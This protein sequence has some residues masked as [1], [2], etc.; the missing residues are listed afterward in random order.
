ML[1][2]DFA[3][4]D[5]PAHR[6]VASMSVEADGW[7]AELARVVWTEQREVRATVGP[8]DPVL[9]RRVV[10]GVGPV[11][12]GRDGTTTIGLH[13]QDASHPMLF[14][15]LDA[16]LSITA[17]PNERARLEILARYDPPLGTAGR[18]I[19]DALLHGL[20]EATIRAFLLQAVAVIEAASAAPNPGDAS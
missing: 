1:V 14:P 20:A 7:L 15:T 8:G 11:H 9:K 16:D 2:R 10:I 4:V 6:V 13:W 12:A 18:V 3:H 19:D 17:L 5:H